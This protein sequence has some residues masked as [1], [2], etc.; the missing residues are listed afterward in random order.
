MILFPW[1]FDK[2]PEVLRWISRRLQKGVLGARSSNPGDLGLG[3]V[4]L[5]FESQGLR[6]LP[7]SLRSSPSGAGGPYYGGPGLER[8][9]VAS[10]V[11]EALSGYLGVSGK[12]YLVLGGYI[13]G[14]PGFTLQQRI[15]CLPETLRSTSVL[16]DCVAIAEMAS[17]W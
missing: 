4:A 10:L 2:K 12:V 16:R 7:R 5:P 13:P 11:P 6:G 15:R 1:A 9:G 14:T 3:A 17:G 8:G